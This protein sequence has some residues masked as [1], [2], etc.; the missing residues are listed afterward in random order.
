[1]AFRDTHG[2]QKKIFTVSQGMAIMYEILSDSVFKNVL[3]NGATFLT[4]FHR[5][6]EEFRSRRIFNSLYPRFHQ[7]A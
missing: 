4:I 5:R 6:G 7:A 3:F 2:I 1:M